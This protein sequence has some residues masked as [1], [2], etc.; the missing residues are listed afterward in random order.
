MNKFGFQWQE[1]LRCEKLPVHSAGKLCMGQNTSE[2]KAGGA[3]S[4]A[5]PEPWTSSPQGGG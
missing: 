4:A 5:P 1:T 2:W 3:T